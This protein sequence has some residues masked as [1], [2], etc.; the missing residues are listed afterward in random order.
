MASDISVLEEIDVLLEKAKEAEE[1][2]SAQ[3]EV[4]YQRLVSL[5][6]DAYY[7]EKFALFA[8]NDVNL[9]NLATFICDRSFFE[10]YI[11]RCRCNKRVIMKMLSFVNSFNV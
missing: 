10:D 7:A 5:S 6:N 3:K 9:H 1:E 11:T 8:T 2:L 4:I